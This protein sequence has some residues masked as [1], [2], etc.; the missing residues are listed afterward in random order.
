M[1]HKKLLIYGLQHRSSASHTGHEPLIAT[2]KMGVNSV[3]SIIS[4]KK[5][6]WLISV[7]HE[8]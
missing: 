7:S 4:L 8:I 2:L 6:A 5:P 1:T 3:I